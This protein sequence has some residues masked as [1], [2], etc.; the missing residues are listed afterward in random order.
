MKVLFA[1]VFT[2]IKD[3]LRSITKGYIRSTK[4][5]HDTHRS[6]VTV[7][8]APV[9]TSALVRTAD[10]VAY[11]LLLQ[12]KASYYLASQYCIPRPHTVLLVRILLNI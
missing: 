9:F 1:A 10:P 8:F 4:K 6:G 7:V 11:P 3:V 12:V 2:C 5:L